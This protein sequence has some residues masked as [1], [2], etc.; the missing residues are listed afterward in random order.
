MINNYKDNDNI[1]YLCGNIAFA[2]LIFYHNKINVSK[3]K[4]EYN[5][6]LG[7]FLLASLPILYKSMY[8]SSIGIGDMT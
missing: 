1:L 3:K 7:N 6:F 8:I 4:N 2:V 5:F